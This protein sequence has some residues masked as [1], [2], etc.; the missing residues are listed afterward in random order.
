M[1]FV[2]LHCTLQMSD[3][4]PYPTV[5]EKE[6]GIPVKFLL[7]KVIVEPIIVVASMNAHEIRTP[8]KPFKTILKQKKIKK[9]AQ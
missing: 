9:N 8:K 4:A 6:A 7:Y 5:L 3:S 2:E 1:Q